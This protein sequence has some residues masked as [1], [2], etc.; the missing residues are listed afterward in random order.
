[1]TGSKQSGF[2]IP[3][4]L[5]I[6]S[7]LITLAT[8]LSHQARTQIKALQRTQ[9]QWHN[10][11]IYRSVL[12]KLIHSLLTGQIAYNYVQIDQQKL[13]IDGRTITID[14][15]DIQI[16]DIAGLMALGSYQEEPFYR[17]LLQLIAPK[18]A[19][20]ISQELT[21]W[22]DKNNLQQR[23]GME[24][25]DYNQAG[26]PYQP[27]NK[28]IRSLDELLE[29]PSMTFTLYNGSAQQPALRDLL[30]PGAGLN[31]N[32]ATAPKQVL[33]AVL[34]AS[35]E[36]W[37][38]IW[39]ARSAENWPFLQ[40]LLLD[41]PGIFGDLGPFMPAFSYRIRMKIPDQKSLR[42]I[43]KLRPGHNPPYAIQQWYYPDDDR[44][45]N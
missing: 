32:A 35:P 33:R 30:I 1:M 10:E 15:V 14:G 42:V 31:F 18:T 2:V 23:Y 27:R 12:Q 25:G 43:I 8:G 13:P 16:Q 24:A 28:M 34:K 41:F 29:L 4:T 45:Q 22:I 17:L 7:I 36:Q 26:L 21:D 3:L 20:R 6:I 11:L 19:R 5:I 39:T 40:R 9:T 37:Q 44:G 38:A